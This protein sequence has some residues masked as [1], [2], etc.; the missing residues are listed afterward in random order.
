[1]SHQMINFTPPHL[2]IASPLLFSEA[3]SKR[4]KTNVYLKL[5][6]LQPSGSFKNR[7]IGHFCCA[8]QKQGA[9][10]FICSSG[11]NAGLAAAYASRRL[12]VPIT[13]VV[14]ESTSQ[15]MINKIQEEQAHVVQIGKDWQEADHY[16]QQQCR[17]HK[18]IYVPPFDHPLIWTG[19]ATMIHEIAASG[20]RPDAFIVSVGGGGLYCGV[21][22]GLND[23]GWEHVPVFA[24]ETEGAASFAAGLQAGRVVELEKIET[25]AKSLGARAVTPK[26]IEYAKS[27]KTQ[28]VVV[29]DSDAVQA[30]VEFSYDHRLLVEPACGAALSLCSAN[31]FAL[32]CFEHVVVIVCGGASITCEQLLEGS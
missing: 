29:S 4:A 6:S 10:Q 24:V 22:E 11:G 27:S 30:C 13:I 16:A 14:P 21:M 1:M 20:L 9:K 12:G 5:E 25:V 17:L 23:V 2:H 28:S 3:L 19:H 8:L 18:A 26:A 32:S 15:T 31:N 7:G